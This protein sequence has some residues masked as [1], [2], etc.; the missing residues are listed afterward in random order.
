MRAA[1]DL[2]KGLALW[3]TLQEIW[4]HI[5]P[6]L[7]LCLTLAD[8]T[9]F[10]SFTGLSTV[11][12]AAMRKKFPQPQPVDGEGDDSVRVKARF[13]DDTENCIKIFLTGYLRDRGM[14][15]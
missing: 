13:L 10:R 3:Q 8:I 2:E 7:P 1:Q 6:S 15:L 11:Q 12:P 5:R 14:M 4:V 9:Q